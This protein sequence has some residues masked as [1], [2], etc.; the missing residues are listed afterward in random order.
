MSTPV[1]FALVAECL[2]PLHK[3]I[4]HPLLPSPIELNRQLI[5]VDRRHIPVAEFLMKHPVTQREG[6]DGASGFG[7]QLA[8]DGERQAARALLA[9]APG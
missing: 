1:S 6:G 3:T 7:H 2:N 8:F 5:P 4:H 9:G